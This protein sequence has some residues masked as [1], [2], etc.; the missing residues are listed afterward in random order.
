MN[1]EASIRRIIRLFLIEPGP[2]TASR[3][4]HRAA[5]QGRRLG[6]NI[7]ILCI[8]EMLHQHA[9]TDHRGDQLTIYSLTAKGRDYARQLGLVP[10]EAVGT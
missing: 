2:H 10:A 3:I 1:S 7:R 5:V 6:D 4:E 8:N 9:Y